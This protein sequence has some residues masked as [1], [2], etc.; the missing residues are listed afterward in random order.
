MTIHTNKKIDENIQP[1]NVGGS[2][3][4]YL[5]YQPMFYNKYFT[6]VALAKMWCPNDL[7]HNIEFGAVVT[8]FD[9]ILHMGHMFQ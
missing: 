8:F 4:N 9:D 1:Q 2:F 7:V 6:H 5:N 3:G